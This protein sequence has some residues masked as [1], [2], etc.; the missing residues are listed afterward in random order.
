MS[1]AE[2]PQEQRLDEIFSKFT[3]VRHERSRG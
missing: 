2:N 3:E 1:L